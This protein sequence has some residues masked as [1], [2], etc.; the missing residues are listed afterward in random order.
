MKDKY[1]SKFE[2]IRN[3]IRSL[4]KDLLA[5]LPHNTHVRVGI[6]CVLNELVN[7]K[8]N[9]YSQLHHI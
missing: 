7:L 9:F 6:D 5:A 1:D 3:M 2:N 4:E 8:T